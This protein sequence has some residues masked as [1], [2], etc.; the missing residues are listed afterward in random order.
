MPAPSVPFRV[1]FV[2]TGNICRSPLAERLLRAQLAER[3]AGD[4]EQ[5]E[6]TSAGARALVDEPMDPD[7]AAALTEL[8]GDPEGF[9]ARMLDADL[10][11]RSD[12]VLGVT[13]KHRATVARL[14]PASVKRAFTLREF[15]RLARVIDPAELP[16]ESARERLTAAVTEAA[17]NRGM[18]RAAQHGDDDVRDPFGG[19]SAEHREAG[20]R[21][22]EAMPYVA[23]LL[24]LGAHPHPHP[25]SRVDHA[26]VVGSAGAAR[27]LAHDQRGEEG[28]GGAGDS[29]ARP[30]AHDQPG[31]EGGNRLVREADDPPRPLAHDQRRSSRSHSRSRAWR[32]ALVIVGVLVGAALWL[33]W[34]GVTAKRN[35][36]AARPLVSEIKAAV[37]AGDTDTAQ[38]KLD[39]LQGHTGK[40]RGAADSRTW[41]AGTHLPWVGDDL[42]AVRAVA[43]VVDDAA[44]D[45]A[46][47]LVDVG[48]TMRPE[49]LLVSGNQVDVEPLAVARP[50]LEKAAARSKRLQARVKT[51]DGTT[52]A[53]PVKTALTDVRAQVEELAQ[54]TD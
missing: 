45:I 8:G 11:K 13:R 51:I 22:A 31:G 39:D 17:V 18:M 1:L 30:L 37:L 2:C 36:E 53:Q 23:D 4:A 32:T 5:I 28:E 33:G 34:Q 35:L 10:I 42:T 15:A 41:S 43:R 7:S 46:P 24:A 50:E 20:A 40:A 21:I 38:T 48:A 44:R 52:A 3:L 54:T 26:Q 29:A 12:L 27:P 25:S 14:D 49:T 19:T 6:V 47:G 16:G 9:R